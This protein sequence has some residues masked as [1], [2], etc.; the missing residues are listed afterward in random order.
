MVT[1]T[2]AWPR[3]RDYRQ[4]R[5]LNRSCVYKHIS[6]WRPSYL[7]SLRSQRAVH[8]THDHGHAP[9][10]SSIVTRNKLA[11]EYPHH[12]ASFFRLPLANFHHAREMFNVLG[13]RSYAVVA[14]A[15]QHVQ[16]KLGPSL[17]S[18]ED[19]N[20]NSKKLLRKDRALLQEDY[21]R[22]LKL[23]TYW[24]KRD[25][26]LLIVPHLQQAGI[27]DISLLD[28]LKVATPK[29]AAPKVTD[30]PVHPAPAKTC[31][32]ITHPPLQTDPAIKIH[33]F[34]TNSAETFPN[35]IHSPL[36][37]DP[38]IEIHQFECF[39]VNKCFEVTME[40]TSTALKVFV[41]HP[42]IEEPLQATEV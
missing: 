39:W 41:S 21:K 25:T 18:K 2:S 27:W 33:Q 31:A 28:D 40:S 24:S 29:A 34:E 16:L 26:L 17:E 38:A 12:P 30:S 1:G 4:T 5:G 6:Y 36:G 11:T 13:S 22:R 19:S 37:V 20:D 14:E 10:K 15:S 8:T 23:L 3:I 42:D 9:A 32:N 35:D 7:G